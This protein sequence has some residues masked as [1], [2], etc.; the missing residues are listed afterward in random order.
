MLILDLWGISFHPAVV[1]MTFCLKVK[2]NSSKK[3]IKKF[4]KKFVKKFYNLTNI[5]Q[6]TKS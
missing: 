3:F 2:K 5:P 4:I 6:N 1:V